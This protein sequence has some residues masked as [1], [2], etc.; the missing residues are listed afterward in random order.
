MVRMDPL[1]TLCD[2]QGIIPPD[3][4]KAGMLAARRDG[5]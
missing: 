5:P 4:R 1:H 3:R 2:A